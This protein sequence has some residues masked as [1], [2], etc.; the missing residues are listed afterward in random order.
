MEIKNEEVIYLYILVVKFLIE[1]YSKFKKIQ[2]QPFQTL[3]YSFKVQRT[4][5]E[6]NNRSYKLQP[7]QYLTS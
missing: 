1:A 3:Q 4:I 6:N 2:E 5:K 7:V